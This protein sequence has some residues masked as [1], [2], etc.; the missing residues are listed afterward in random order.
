VIGDIVSL[1]AGN[2]VKIIATIIISYLIGCAY[3]WSDLRQSRYN[4]PGYIR[5]GRWSAVVYVLSGCRSIHG[6]PVISR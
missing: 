6:R 2:A 3:V 1:G 4:K 5:S